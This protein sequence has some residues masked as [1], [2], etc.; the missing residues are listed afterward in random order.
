MSSVDFDR[1]RGVVLQRVDDDSWEA[2]TTGV[3]YYHWD[4]H[5]GFYGDVYVQFFA[6]TSPGADPVLIASGVSQ[7]VDLGGWLWDDSAA[8]MYAA[9]S[10]SPSRAGVV[11]ASGALTLDTNGLS[12]TGDAY[13]VWVAYSTAAI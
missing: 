11:V 4:Q 9:G 8:T 2:P 13:N 5:G 7:A 3:V 1:A 6:A 10:Y 12:D